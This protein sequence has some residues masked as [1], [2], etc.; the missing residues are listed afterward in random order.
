MKKIILI[1]IFII[2]LF[3]IINNAQAIELLLKGQYPNIGGETIGSGSTLPDVIKY[4]YLFSLAAVGFI[5]L[6]AIMIGA[7]QYVTSAGNP[8]RAGEAKDRIFQAL[9]GIVILLAAV[10]LLRTI[11]P[12]LIDLGT[13][14]PPIN[15]TSPH[16][17][18]CLNPYEEKGMLNPCYEL[19]PNACGERDWVC[20]DVID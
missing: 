20:V 4:V 11:N 9:L 13:E 17:C 7:I 1:I 19:C 6:L 3:G 18:V 12:D 2:A 14:L 10:L 16:K 5:A 8:S 15:P